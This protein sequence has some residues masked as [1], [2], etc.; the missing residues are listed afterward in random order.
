M[1]TTYISNMFTGDE[2]RVNNMMKM[3]ATPDFRTLPQG[4][5]WFASEDGRYFEIGVRHTDLVTSSD[6]ME[7]S[8]DL[9]TNGEANTAIGVGLTLQVQGQTAVSQ[10]RFSLDAKVLIGTR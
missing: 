2:K 6:A 3:P 1:K 4:L 9:M 5:K 8:S 7:K 10:G